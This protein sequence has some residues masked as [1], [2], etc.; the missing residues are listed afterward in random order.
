[1]ELL[2]LLLEHPYVVAIVTTSFYI[3]LTA[4]YRLYLSPIAHFPGPRLAA[5]TTAYEFYWEAIRNGRYTFH[6]GD[7]HKKYGTTVSQSLRHSTN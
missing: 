6:I 5:L 2:R 4:I 7:L 1:M 3:T